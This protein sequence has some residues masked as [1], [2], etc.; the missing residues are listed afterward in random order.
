MPLVRMLRLSNPTIQM[1]FLC[2]IAYYLIVMI[3]FQGH[4]SWSGVI[5]LLC[6]F[7]I[8]GLGYEEGKD[9]QTSSHFK[10]RVVGTF[11]SIAGESE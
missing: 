6:L 5:L 8:Y 7:S 1:I 9:I 3:S 10:Y 4:L 2:G 11:P